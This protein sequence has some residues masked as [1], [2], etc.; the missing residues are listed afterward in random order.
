MRITN[1]MIMNNAM[2]NIN[3]NKMNVDKANAM[4]FTEKKISRPSED[5]I[6]AVRALRLRNDLN[7]VNQYYEKNVEDAESWMDLTET[8][9]SNMRTAVKSMYDCYMRGANGYLDTN[10]GKAIKDEITALR[11]EIGSICN[12]TNAGRYI[13]TG[14]KTSTKFTLD[15]PE[16][17]MSYEIT[18]SFI[19]KEIE[20]QEY[21]SNISEFDRTN[22]VGVAESDM[23]QSNEI[24]RIALGYQKLGDL[25]EFTYVDETGATQTV[26]VTT[27][28][29]DGTNTDD[30]YLNV[31]AGGANYIADTGELILSKDLYETLVGL[32]AA[33]DGTNPISITYQKTG[34]DEGDAR[35]EMYYDCTDLVSGI[36]YKKEIQDIEYTV[37]F[38]QKLK[39]N[40][41]ISH[42]IGR[43][44]ARNIDDMLN[45][46]QRVEDA[47]EKVDEIQKMIDS[48][49]Y[50]GADLENLKTSLA[51]AE[52][53]LEL[54]KK[55]YMD[56]MGK[57]VGQTQNYEALVTEAI[58]D[59]GNRMS[60]LYLIKER[61]G[62]QQTNFEELKSQNENVEL[63][64]ALLELT[65]AKLAYEAALSAT[66][67]I[68][69]MSL[70]NYL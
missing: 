33:A 38:S 42:V 65:A 18:Q 56:I 30:A 17:A 27:Y 5:P 40:T 20:I 57:G 24:Y 70:L 19:G 14:Y 41:E 53:E 16:P 49:K 6:T 9:L 3:T 55:V 64:D 29:L 51:S 7:E 22:I 45:A 26:D 67:T 52:K 47:Q 10:D 15:A 2:T 31:A 12:S 21:I 46:I 50:T 44:M 66:G 61:L 58:S 13:F 23:P 62:E 54:Q 69:Q 39:V 35:P 25:G 59:T 63:S 1:S 11:D 60:R 68:S 8:A 32:E 48:K 37:N 28:N 43:E 36:V 4:V 34:F